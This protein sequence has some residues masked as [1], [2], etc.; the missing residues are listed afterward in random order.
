MKSPGPTTTSETV[1]IQ[2][3]GTNDGCSI[4]IVRTLPNNSDSR[5]LFSWTQQSSQ[6]NDQSTLSKSAQECN[7]KCSSPYG[8]RAVTTV[9]VPDTLTEANV[10]DTFTEGSVPAT[11]GLWSSFNNIDVSAN[12]LNDVSMDISDLPDDVSRMISSIEENGTQN[13]H[14]PKPCVVSIEDDNRTAQ[15]VPS[16]DCNEP[17]A[18]K[19]KSGHNVS[20]QI[21]AHKTNQ[22][23]NQVPLQASLKRN[24]GS[25]DK[26]KRDQS[27]NLAD[28]SDLKFCQRKPKR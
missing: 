14:G 4:S 26:K 1:S 11:E 28:I 21:S 17:N 9:N 25:V 18:R 12:I 16:D 24:V 19:P 2:Q 3:D 23:R 6:G 10:P 13:L 8:S 5:R 20:K 7:S 22:V 27:A 15:D